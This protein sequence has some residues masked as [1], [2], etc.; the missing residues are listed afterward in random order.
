[1]PL[2]IT[3]RPDT[4]TLEL[5]IRGT[6]AATDYAGAMQPLAEMIEA[7]GQ[8]SVVEIVESFSGFVGEFPE[9]MDEAT[10]ALLRKIRRVALVSDF[11]WSCPILS[12]APLSG[13]MQIK[14]FELKETQA[15]RNWVGDCGCSEG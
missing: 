11:G 8:V 9:A 1:M 4:C 12:N 14:S 15:A 2:T 10:Q 5:T 3:A 7:C 13:S 6:L